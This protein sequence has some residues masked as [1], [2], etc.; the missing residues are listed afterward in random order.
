MSGSRNTRADA[1]ASDGARILCLMTL[2][3]VIGCATAGFILSPAVGA[4]PSGPPGC[5][6]ISNPDT[7]AEGF[8]YVVV[9]QGDVSCP[10]AMNVID[11]YF[12]DSTLE[13]NGNSW[14]AAFD[15]WSCLLPNAMARVYGYRTSCS[16]GT[17]DEV[18]IRFLPEDIA[19]A[20]VD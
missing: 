7:G 14:H 20:P 3:T 13:Y 2:S 15:A 8:G 12:H 9:V 16:R 18:Q 6:V 10:E 4:D 1:I 17:T 19:A 5:G 11:R